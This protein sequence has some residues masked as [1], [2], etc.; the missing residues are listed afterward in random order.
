MFKLYYNQEFITS[1]YQ[2]NHFK[3]EH[4]V[5]RLIETYNDFYKS[6]MSLKN[7]NLYEYNE[8]IEITTFEYNYFPILAIYKLDEILK[9]DI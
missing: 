1:F 6:N 5:K 2:P 3:V 7:C 8:K 9:I 4:D